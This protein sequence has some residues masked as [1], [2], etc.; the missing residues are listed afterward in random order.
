MSDKKPGV[1]SKLK[2]NLFKGYAGTDI[3][4]PTTQSRII[5]TGIG[6]L[7]GGGAGTLMMMALKKK[8]PSLKPFSPMSI[9]QNALSGG[10]YGLYEQDIK[11]SIV[12]SN[13]DPSKKMEALQKIQHVQGIKSKERMSFLPGLQKEA[14]WGSLARSGLK[15]AKTVG[16]GMLPMGKSG[17][18]RTVRGTFGITG[19]PS[20]SQRAWGLGVKAGVGTGAFFGGRAAYRKI[21]REMNP[22]SGEYT[23]FLRNNMLAGNIQQNELSLP[24]MESVR[25]L[26]M[27]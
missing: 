2:Y 5:G 8:I 14:F 11:N 15:A 12:R 9:A 26:G 23:T 27:Q 19:N 20:L 21:K 7:V 6:T 4:K 13:L 1:L 24:D 3:V 16:F 18:S 25:N 10:L 17:F 22:R